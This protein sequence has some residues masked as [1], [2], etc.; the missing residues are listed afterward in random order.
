MEEKQVESPT[1]IAALWE[2]YKT[3]C[4]QGMPEENIE[5]FRGCFYSAVLGTYGLLDYI[6]RLDEGGETAQ[7]QAMMKS[8]E[9]E[10]E[11]YI[12]GDLCETPQARDH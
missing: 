6:A 4:L 5:F 3:Q 2:I 10:V 1:T 9:D 7:S 12:I 8:L 11:Q